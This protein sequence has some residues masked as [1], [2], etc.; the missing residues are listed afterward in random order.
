MPKVRDGDDDQ[1]VEEHSEERNE[2]EQDV[3]QQSLIARMCWCLAGV[4]QLWKT[5]FIHWHRLRDQVD[6]RCAD[7]FH[8]KSLEATGLLFLHSQWTP[9]NL[10]FLSAVHATA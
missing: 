4:V 5:I 7:S 3:D 1:Q 10:F 8:A 6:G 9:R 2:G